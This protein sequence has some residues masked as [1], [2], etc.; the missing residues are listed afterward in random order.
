VDRMN[1][2]ESAQSWVDILVRSAILAGLVL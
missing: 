1:T 2:T